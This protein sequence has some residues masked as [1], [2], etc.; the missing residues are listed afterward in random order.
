M[1]IQLKQITM[2][3]AIALIIASV[4]IEVICQNDFAYIKK[5]TNE[6]L[7]VYINFQM[8]GQELAPQGSSIK[9]P[10]EKLV[11]SAKDIEHIIRLKSAQ[12]VC[13]CAG[14]AFMVHGCCT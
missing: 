12:L 5:T 2:Y 4:V 7:D 3:L 9:N 11:K 14:I 8:T 13:L 1:K 10:K 6:M